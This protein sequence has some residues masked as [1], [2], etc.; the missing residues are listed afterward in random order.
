MTMHVKTWL[1]TSTLA[2]AISGVVHAGVS[3]DQAARLGKDLTPTGAEKA[4]NA[5]GSIPAWTGGLNSSNDRYANPYANEKPLFTIT[6]ANAAQYKDK[7]SA[8]QL[9]LLEKYPDTFKM[10]VYPTHR[11]AALPDKVYS[12]I[13]ANATSAELKDDGNGISGF[14]EAIPFPFHKVVWK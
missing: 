1:I 11:S 6:A 5:D 7:L 13:A 3:P 9:A 4:G 14:N 2:L 10:N 8:G 12:A